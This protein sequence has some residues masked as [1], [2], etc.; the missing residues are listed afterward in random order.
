MAQKLQ[1]IL[2][3]ATLLLLLNTG[4]TTP[5]SAQAQNAAT[6]S[7]LWLD[8]SLGPPLVD[9]FNRV[10]EPDDIARAENIANLGLLD[11][12]TV[13]RKLLVFR[14]IKEAEEMLPAIANRIDIVGYNLEQNSITPSEE[15]NDPVTS[16]K[17]MREL[18]NTYN[19]QLAFG[20]DHF[21]ALNGGV[22]IAPYVDIFV[23]QVQRVQTQPN[24]VRDFVLPLVPQLRQANPNLQISV[25]IRTEG[26][27][28]ALVDLVDSLKSNLAGVSVLTSPETVA[29]AADLVAQLQTRRESPPHI[30]ET[31]AASTHINQQ[32]ESPDTNSPITESPQ[33][34]GTISWLPIILVAL[35]AGAA[36]GGI[37]AFSIRSR[38]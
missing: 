9:W 5:Q 37:V 10:A 34:G 23:L 29:V 38:R 32:S 16:A 31:E 36:A 28:V 30:A 27:V 11:Q 24:T 22:E 33:T 2:T 26:D 14:S 1:F 6:V 3:I 17:R 35:I 8:I 15:Q 25:Q 21:F 13:G 7:D 19:L 20:P 4:A 18:A 12:I